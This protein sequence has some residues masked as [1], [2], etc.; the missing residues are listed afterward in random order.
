[1]VR[2]FQGVAPRSLRKALLGVK[3]ARGWEKVYLHFK[4]TDKEFAM[5]NVLK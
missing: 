3:L 4:G 2:T 1:M 5:T